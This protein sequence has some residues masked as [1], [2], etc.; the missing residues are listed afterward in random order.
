MIRVA[1]YNIRK[2][3]GLD[4]RRRPERIVEV[5]AQLRADVVAVQEADQRFG[6]RRA[7]LS[8]DAL[9]NHA[10]LRIA[11]VNGSPHS[12][13]WHGNAILIGEKVTLKAAAPIDLPSLEPRGALLVELELG[14]RTLRVVGAHLGLRA[15][16]RRRQA[17][18]ILEALAARGGG[19]PEVVLGDLNEWR[20]N[21]GCIPVFAERLTVTTPG[22]SFHTSAPFA[23]LD[24]V[25]HSADM[26]PLASGVHTSAEAQRASD[27]LPVWADL[28]PAD[29]A[30]TTGSAGQAQEATP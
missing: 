30:E 16:N 17:R 26:R 18:A 6:Q 11:T 27:H 4:W 3:V 21:G 8:A 7:T 2:C 20:V 10:G 24:R 25:M 19:T 22:N 29:N 23:A 14:A 15:R 28:A 13:G 12:H 1:S 9:L 5:L